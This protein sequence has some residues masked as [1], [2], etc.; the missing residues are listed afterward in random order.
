MIG[1]RFLRDNF[2]LA[3]HSEEIAGNGLQFA[4]CNIY[5]EEE[6]DDKS[7]EEEDAEERVITTMTKI[8]LSMY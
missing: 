5:K 6:E 8:F 1:A 4:S 7:G 3:H 2:A